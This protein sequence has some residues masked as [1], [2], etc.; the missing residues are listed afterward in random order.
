[1]IQYI[2]ELKDEYINK[3]NFIT[4]K[5]MPQTEMVSRMINEMGLG[6]SADGIKIAPDY[7]T[8]SEGKEIGKGADILIPT[9]KN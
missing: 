2:S 1:S 9:H 8:S 6:I 4:I 5:V 7:G 3:A